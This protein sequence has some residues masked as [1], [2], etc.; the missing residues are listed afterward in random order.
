[1]PTLAG[2]AEQSLD[3]AVGNESAR[4]SEVDILG[5]GVSALS[6]Q[7]VAEDVVRWA[8]TP[9]PKAGP[10]YVCA[11]SV[12]GLVEAAHDPSFREVLNGASRV[13]PDGMPLVWFGRLLG[14]RGMTRVYGPDLMKE[15]CRVTAGLP[16]G[17]F[18]YGGAPG[19][20]EELARRL[21][22]EFPGLDVAGAYSPPY[23]ALSDEEL[24][25]TAQL[26]NDSAARIVWVGLSTPKQERWVAAVRPL[27]EAHVVVTVGAAFDFHTG[28]V[29]QAPRWMQGSGLE[30]LFRLIQEPRRLWRRYGYNL[31]V[32]LWLALL[33]LAGLKTFTNLTETG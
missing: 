32:F 8:T 28:R 21:S 10:H 14:A 5:V 15:I 30:W 17:H 16:V 12:H 19:V 20:P 9:R 23:R 4:P 33:Q 2:A 31:P 7:E 1:M 26:I 27:L 13:T 11:T 29:P 3:Q 22:A 25:S 18:F 6:L 24:E